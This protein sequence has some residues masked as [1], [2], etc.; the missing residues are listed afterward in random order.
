MLDIGYSLPM[1]ANYDQ[2][3]SCVMA[4][5][6]GN[7]IRLTFRFRFNHKAN[8]WFMTI[9]DTRTDTILLDSIPLFEGIGASSDILFQYAYMEIGSAFVQKVGPPDLVGK[10]GPGPGDFPSNYE[11]IWSDT[12]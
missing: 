10:D 2:K 11:V 5:D 8:Y 3:F 4:I 1:T 9:W 7:N 12:V 6:G